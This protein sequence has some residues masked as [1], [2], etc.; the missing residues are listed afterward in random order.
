MD[1]RVVITG[2]GTVCGL[3]IGIA[4]VR[5]A[6]WAGRSALRP[7]TLFDPSG[8]PCRL[9]AEVP[10]FPGAKDFVPRA[11]RKAVKVMA[12]DIELAVAAAMCA[13]SDAGLITRGTLPEGAAEGTTYPSPRMG[14]HI[15]AGLIAAD[16]NELTAALA[17]ARATDA[18]PDRPALDLRVWGNGPGGG[19]AM[20]N[21]PPL[22]LLKYLPNMLACHVTIIHG[23][24]GPSNT[25]TCAE[26]S[27]LLSLGESVRVIQRG[28]ADMCFTG[29]AEA[30]INHMRLLRMDL[31]HRLA[32]TQDG[33]EGWRVVRPYDPQAPGELLGEGGGILIVEDAELATA[34]GAR[35][36]AEIVGFGAAHS[37]PPPDG[38]TGAHPGPE[39]DD[40]LRDAIVAAL[41]DAGLGPE[42]VDA[43][44][45][46]AAGIP[47]VDRG[48]AGALRAVF[49]A[50]LGRIPL[51][52][53]T[54]ALGDCLAGNGGLAAGLAACCLHQQSLPPRLHAG[55]APPDLRAEPA[56]A[57][58]ARLRHILL[59]TGALGGQNAAVVLRRWEAPRRVSPAPS[60]RHGTNS[61]GDLHGPT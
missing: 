7:I 22:W 25:I 5:E 37:S 33:D 16:T 1:R 53:L 60:R 38:W 20:N 46:R 41:D 28:D 58:S 36:Y 50:R 17:T 4:A 55:Q 19:G 57:Q 11:Y 30:P 8:F 31:V 10:D 52:T 24:E 3:G 27:G 13:V 34:R 39:V 43:I 56:D 6:L 14:C 54:P 9:A 2:V 35:V 51:I 15:G 40:G 47:A 48:E 45:P 59:A 29:G 44:V 18:P 23:A 49:G 12:R 26:A 61:S 21:L 42:D 32:H